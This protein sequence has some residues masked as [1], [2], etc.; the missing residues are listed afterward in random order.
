[1]VVAVLALVAAS[2]VVVAPA[3]ADLTCGR[4]PM[5]IVGTS[6]DDVIDGTPEDDV[7]HGLGG[8]D[9]INGGGGDDLICG[10]HGD[11]TLDGGDGADSVW[12][13]GGT[14]WLDGGEG[15]DFV[16]GDKGNDTLY[17]GP[18]TDLL[19]GREGD[20]V[21]YGGGGADRLWGDAGSPVAESGSDRLFGGDGDD[22][23]QGDYGNDQLYGDAGT[24]TLYGGLGDDVLHGGEGSDTMSGDGAHAPPAGSGSDRLF[25]ESG[26]DTLQGNSGNYTLDGG[27]GNDK[28]NGGDG[29]DELVGGVGKDTVSY[30][31][32]SA[33]VTVDLAAGTGGGADQGSDTISG[34]EHVFGSQ[35]GDVLRGNGLRNRLK[36][37]DGA[38]KLY[39]FGGVDTLYGG[40]GIDNLYGGG[41]DDTLI[42]GAGTDR[43]RGGAG[44]DMLQGKADDDRAFGENGDDTIEGNLGDDL[45][46]GGD[47]TDALRGGAGI[48]TCHN[49]EHYVSCE[50]PET[51]P[52][53][54]NPVAYWCFNDQTTP[55]RDGA[56]GHDATVVGAV[57]DTGDFAP[58]EG[59][60]ASLELDGT[61]DY[62]WTPDP[63]GD[64]NLDG[65]N[66]LTLAAWIKP[67]VL[68]SPWGSRI[69][70][71]KYHDA[72]PHNASGYWLLQRGD[73]VEVFVR[74]DD[75]DFDRVTSTGVDLVTGEWVHV[76]GTWSGFTLRLFVNGKQVIYRSR[77]GAVMEDSAAQVNIGSAEAFDNGQ[78]S[79]FFDGHV[80]EVYI[81][82]RVVAPAEIAHLAGL[83]A[84]EAWHSDL[85]AAAGR[86]VEA[87][88]ERDVVKPIRTGAA[89]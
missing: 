88:Y 28:L 58:L 59:N 65:F 40:D 25:G 34:V 52:T 2:L 31:G 76:V 29:D 61:D 45:L 22:T 80:D 86:R 38:D 8:N 5:T 18:G 49:G 79:A 33:G 72:A 26:D 74:Y 14:D 66:G 77:R 42:G 89:Q 3:G 48:D 41:G 15:N 7:I 56:D 68:D 85:G 17:G 1:M 11:D 43:I 39:G 83:E 35:F 63:G 19:A 73:E 67:D 13:N 44:N 30:W 50:P 27:D 78:R 37:L 36:G 24:D 23:I 53:D 57:F 54:T 10:G 51:C 64:D 84:T 21:L 9:I 62:A 82:D 75:G 4:L 6:G 60:V 16:L 47:G 87:S 46:D 69:I 55:T 32:A 20:D 71:S 70:V 81:Y 12:G